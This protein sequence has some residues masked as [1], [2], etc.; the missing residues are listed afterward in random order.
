MKHV[1]RYF[2]TFFSSGKVSDYL[3]MKEEE[4]KQSAQKED[5][6]ADELR[7]M[8]REQESDKDERIY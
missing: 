8:R 6:L 5:F 1:G 2:D 4:R 3:I 7:F